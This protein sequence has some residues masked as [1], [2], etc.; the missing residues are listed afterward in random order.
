MKHRAARL[1]SL[2]MLI[3]VAGPTSLL[4]NQW[5]LHRSHKF[6]V[7]AVGRPRRS[8]ALLAPRDMC[9][10]EPSWHDFGET[11]ILAVTTDF[12]HL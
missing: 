3:V 11:L 9:F 4:C 12:S 1:L 5:Q 7:A 10:V 6:I 2:T 8:N